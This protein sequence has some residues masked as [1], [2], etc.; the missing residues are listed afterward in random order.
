[1]SQVGSVTINGEEYFL[2]HIQYPLQVG[3][4]TTD[5]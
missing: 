2:N 4:V 5:G 1:M 3:I